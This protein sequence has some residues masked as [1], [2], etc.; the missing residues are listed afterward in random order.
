KH[1]YNSVF[2]NRFSNIIPTPR[3][4]NLII[5]TINDRFKTVVQDGTVLRQPVEGLASIHTNGNAVAADDVKAPY[6]LI[7]SPTKQA[8]ESSDPKIDFRD[9]LARNTKAGTTIYEVFALS[10]SE[11]KDLNNR[12]VTKLDGLL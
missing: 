5:R 2:Q 10:E 7:F 8:V 11:E 4:T 6:R 1:S 3:A 12:G 9:D